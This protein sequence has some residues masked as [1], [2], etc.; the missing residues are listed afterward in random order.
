MIRKTSVKQP[1]SGPEATMK[2]PSTAIKTIP[3]EP[4][5]PAKVQLKIYEEA[6]S[7]FSQRKLKEALARFLEA[8]K[9]PDAH[10]ADKSRSYLQVCERRL[11]TAE[12]VL[13]TAEDHFNYGVER[14]NSRDF[15]RAQH[16][17]KRALEL[18]PDAEYIYYT[19]AL[20]CG[21]AGDGAAACE[22]LKRAIDLQPKNRILAR[23]DPEFLGLVS[24]FPGL[25][26][27]LSETA[28]V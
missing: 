4:P 27:L 14:L 1:S 17:F 2:G 10:V 28:R 23:Q 13:K 9:G 8:A 7:L 18:E 3:V 26:A 22:N 20:C 5:S 16:H 25:R 19:L 24:Q 15:E 12:P 6:V 11:V 21:L